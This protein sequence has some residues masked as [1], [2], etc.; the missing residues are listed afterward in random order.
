[1]VGFGLARPQ[2][3]FTFGLAR[4]HLEIG[5]P[6]TT[7]IKCVM[8]APADTEEPDENDGADAAGELADVTAVF[9]LRMGM[10]AVT[11][12]KSEAFN[13]WPMGGSEWYAT[14]YKW[15]YFSRNSFTELG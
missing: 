6:P 5:G 13:P 14:V 2:T 10:D 1:M 11:R 15:G 12:D 7:E 4:P 3:L 9:V 8:H